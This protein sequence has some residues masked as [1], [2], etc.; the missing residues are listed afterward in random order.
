MIHIMQKEYA[1]PDLKSEYY[2]NLRNL[3]TSI[4]AAHTSAAELNRIYSEVLRKS[5]DSPPQTMKQFFKLWFKT[6]DKKFLERLA[7]ISNDYENIEKNPTEK[8]L[9]ELGTKL[10]K[11]NQKSISELEIYEIIM[12]EFYKAWRKMWP[13]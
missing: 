2:H 4:Q 1:W 3:Q 12:A 5:S 7:D 9:Q 10:Q 13:K 11:L 6:M 8:N